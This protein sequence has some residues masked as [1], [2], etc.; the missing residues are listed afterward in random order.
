[1]KRLFLFLLALIGTPLVWV[2]GH[3]FLK[4]L[5]V[6]WLDQPLWTAPR[7]A[8]VAGCVTMMALYAWKAR[9]MVVLYVFAHEVTHALAGLC[10][11][12]R[13]H[14]I[15]IRA[16]GGFV[17]LS[18]SNL[19][20]TLAP[21]CVPLYLLVAVFLYCVQQYLLSDALPFACWAFLFGV[22]TVFHICYTTDALFS[23]SQPDTLEYGR[24]FSWWL[25]LVANLFF[26]VFAIT[27]TSPNYTVRHQA[28]QGVAVTRQV[29]HALYAGATRI[30]QRLTADSASTSEVK[31]QP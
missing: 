5:A 28:A 31:G 15:S 25:I 12:A 26:A 1:M 11:F 14:Q 9:A 8:F 10:C 18:K 17:R 21:Y 2:L 24:F 30:V 7:I 23:V 13:I 20:I 4:T 29:Y 3:C 22:L 19:V 6:D 27:I 16:T